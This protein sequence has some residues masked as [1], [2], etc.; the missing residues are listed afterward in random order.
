[1]VLN[2]FV[3]HNSLFVRKSYVYGQ[4]YMYSFKSHYQAK[5]VRYKNCE[6]RI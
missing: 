5:F 6:F 3:N 1:M 2:D 4:Q